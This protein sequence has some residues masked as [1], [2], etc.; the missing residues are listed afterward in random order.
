MIHGKT[1]A[2]EKVFKAIIYSTIYI[3]KLQNIEDSLSY[4]LSQDQSLRI[5]IFTNSQ[6]AQ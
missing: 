5:Q 2:T 1:K 3:G 4:I 6:I